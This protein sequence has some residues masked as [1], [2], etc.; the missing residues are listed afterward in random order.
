MSIVRLTTHIRAATA[1]AVLA[2][3]AA[4]SGGGAPTEVNPVTTP[5]PV[6][7]YTGP[8]P[9]NADVQAFRINLWENIKAS[10]RCGGCHNAG[11]QTPNF[12][13]NDDVNLAYQAAIALVAPAQPDQTLGRPVGNCRRCDLPRLPC[14]K[15]RQRP[16][17]DRR[18]RAGGA[19]RTG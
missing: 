4:C 11:G 3:L 15:L 16:H 10:N 6:A 18:P 8:A 9:A 19:V 17:P 2:T 5:P 12:A 14:R 7:D 1:L 13:R